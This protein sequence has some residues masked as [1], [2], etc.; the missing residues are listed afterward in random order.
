MF[1][2][3]LHNKRYMCLKSFWI[4]KH[5][6]EVAELSKK[7]IAQRQFL[8]ALAS[9]RPNDFFQRTDGFLEQKK[10]KG[11]LSFLK[12]PCKHDQKF[13]QEMNNEYNFYKEEIKELSQKVKE[14]FKEI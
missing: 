7:L 8:T 11:F 4:D 2:V 3:D 9:N 6:S 10:H 12:R 13:I 5:N 1:K 14:T